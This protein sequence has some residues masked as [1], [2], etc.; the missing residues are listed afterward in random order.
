M[1]A[2][3][4]LASLANQ[5]AIL[6]KCTVYPWVVAVGYHFTPGVHHLGLHITERRM[7]DAPD[8][9][10]FLPAGAELNRAEVLPAA[11]LDDM[12]ARGRE[13]YKPHY[14]AYLMWRKAKA[15]GKQPV[16]LQSWA[17]Y[18]PVLIEE[19][20]QRWAAPGVRFGGE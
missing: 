5:A 18:D 11:R 9:L 6:E 8:P 16:E 3:D 17:D 10:G 20:V 14:R 2:N 4:L 15:I 13:R 12:P 19:D 1:G 7:S